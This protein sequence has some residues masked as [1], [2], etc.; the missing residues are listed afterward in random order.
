LAVEIRI[1]FGISRGNLDVTDFAVGV[2][3][4]HKSAMVGENLG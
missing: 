3:G 2:S 1:A 4:R